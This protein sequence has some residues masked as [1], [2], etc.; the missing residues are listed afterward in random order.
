M[1]YVNKGVIGMITFEKEFKGDYYN[2][3]KKLSFLTSHLSS[4]TAQQKRFIVGKLKVISYNESDVN[5]DISEWEVSKIETTLSTICMFTEDIT[6]FYKLF[7]KPYCLYNNRTIDIDA[8]S[9][10]PLCIEQMPSCTFDIKRLMTPIDIPPTPQRLTLTHTLALLSWYGADISLQTIE[11]LNIVKMISHN[12]ITF[13]TQSRQQVTID[14]SADLYAKQIFED[15]I[16][17]NRQMPYVLNENVFTNCYKKL[18]V[19]KK[20][21]E[22]GGVYTRMKKSGITFGTYDELKQRNKHLTLQK[23]SQYMDVTFYYSGNVFMSRTDW[24][25]F[26]KRYMQWLEI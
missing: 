6:D 5:R 26:Y 13:F 20:D 15:F 17:Y 9:L 25:K 11:K 16:K 3:E 7:L 18:G 21:L 23:L 8:D 22:C 19:A 10:T 24:D 1:K 14:F 12:Q 2:K 4:I